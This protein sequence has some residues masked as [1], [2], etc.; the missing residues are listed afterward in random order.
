MLNH[1]RPRETKWQF[2]HHLQGFTIVSMQGIG[3][4]LQVYDSY[5]Q[6]CNHRFLLN[7][8]FSVENNVEPDGFCPNEVPILLTLREDDP[9]YDF[10]CSYFRRETFLPS[11]RLR[12]CVAENENFHTLITFLRIIVA[13]QDDINQ[14]TNSYSG[15]GNTGGGVDTTRMGRDMHSAL[16][17]SNELRAMRLLEA[18]IKKLLSQYPAPL[19]MDLDRLTNDK[20]LAPFSNERHAIIQVKGEKEVLQFFLE[21]AQTVMHLLSVRDPDLFRE[22][23]RKVQ[24]NTKHQCLFMYLRGNLNAIR[25]WRG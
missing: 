18:T 12:I 7:Y 24:D 8:G 19:D 23:M 2:D 9:L 6:K 5:G 17:E 25:P 3:S 22:E 10:K 21:F 13:D 20:T 15:A 11:K 4:G 1:Y 14:L 16:N